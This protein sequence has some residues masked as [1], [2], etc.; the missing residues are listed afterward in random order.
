MRSTVTLYGKP[1]C[2]L[3]EDARAVVLAIRRERDFELR[4]VDI[5]LDPEMQRAYGERIPVVEVD[6]REAFQYH[7]DPARLRGLLVGERR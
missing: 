7:V 1:E 6:G 2:H 5:S 4:E 3:C